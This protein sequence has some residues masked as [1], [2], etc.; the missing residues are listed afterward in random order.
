MILSYFEIPTRNIERAQ[1]FYES[2]FLIDLI[3]KDTS[4]SKEKIF[5]L[6]GN[7]HEAIGALVH[8]DFHK[9]SEEGVLIY[10]KVHDVL[11]KFIKRIEHLGGK[12]II[13]PTPIDA[14]SGH[15]CIFRDTEGNRIGIHSNH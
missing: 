7:V 12:M 10:F 5:S 15:Y 1:E 14:G 13:A 6:T 9:V 3:D 2:V 4:Y 11:E 8:D